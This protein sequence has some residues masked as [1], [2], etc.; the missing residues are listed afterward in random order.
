MA[1]DSDVKDK[2]D[3]VISQAATPPS[4]PSADAQATIAATEARLRVLH[5][6]RTEARLRG[7]F[8]SR[9]V[10]LLRTLR[11]RPHPRGVRDLQTIETEHGLRL[12]VDVGDRLGCD[13]F[14][15]YYEEAFEARLFGAVI[16]PGATVVDVGANFG[17]YTVIGARAAGPTGRIYAFEPDPGAR[18]LLRRNV[19][20]NG[21][22]DRVTILPKDFRELDASPFDKVLSI[23]MYEAVGLENR[24]SYF[25]GVEDQLRPCGA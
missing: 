15:G 19:E 11:E 14:Y 12:T 2:S 4:D 5:G 8:E 13:V 22:R 1:R 3:G 21:F 24:E 16:Q 6:L 18:D 9:Y 25:K 7:D 23:D 20:A 10:D 17:Y